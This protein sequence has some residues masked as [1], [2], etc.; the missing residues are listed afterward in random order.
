VPPAESESAAAAWQIAPTREEEGVRAGEEEAAAGTEEAE[1]EQKEQAERAGEAAEAEAAAAEE[2]AELEEPAGA[3]EAAG[4][5]E[6]EEELAPQAD[7]FTGGDPYAQGGL[8][9]RLPKDAPQ[10]AEPA[11]DEERPFTT[12]DWRG[13]PLS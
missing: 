11:A 13:R 12:F 6:T 5:E 4:R 10:P 2:A 3:E 1:A 9:R 8:L 7:G